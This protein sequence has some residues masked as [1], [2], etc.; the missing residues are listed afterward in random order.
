MAIDNAFPT[1]ASTLSTMAQWEKFFTGMSAD[2]VIPGVLNELVPSLNAG[3][4]TAV[5]GTGAAEI[6]GFHVDNPSA[7]STAIPA[8]D[9]QNRIDRLVLRLDRTASEADDWI[10]PFVIEGAPSNS[11]QIP[12][13]SQT[14]GGN[15][16]IP[17]AR[18][19]ATSTGSLTGL[20]DE[21]VFAAASPVEFRSDARPSPTLRRIGFERDTGKVMWANGTAWSTV[22]DDTG[23][24]AVT[25]APKWRSDGACLAR[26]VGAVASVDM[27]LL[28]GE[29]VNE[30]ITKANVS[31]LLVATVAPAFRPARNKYVVG[32]L[33]GG[34]QVRLQVQPDGK[35]TAWH[36]SEDLN[37]QQTLRVS[38]T[39]LV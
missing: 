2:G 9:A 11:P 12:A 35:I 14:S 7:T 22:S 21:R 26:K 24:V 29:V 3:A 33:S 17:I 28:F 15:Y 13:L 8:A 39:Y 10:K 27:N 38:T 4:R 31:N 37:Y 6:R 16:D 20:V 30:I 5:L 36:S 18:W 23:D 19:T 34:G 1:A 25:L 32:G